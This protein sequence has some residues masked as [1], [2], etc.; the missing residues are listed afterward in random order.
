[1]NKPPIMQMLNDSFFPRLSPYDINKA[2]SS[3]QIGDFTIIVKLQNML[4][5]KYTVL[6]FLRTSV[7]IV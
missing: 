1:M 3:K 6:T 2:F 4:F 5:W 7:V